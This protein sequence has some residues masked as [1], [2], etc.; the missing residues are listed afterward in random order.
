[1]VVVKKGTDHRGTLVRERERERERKMAALYLLMLPV[2]DFR[3]ITA[4]AIGE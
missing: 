1:M 2:A 4:S 3:Y